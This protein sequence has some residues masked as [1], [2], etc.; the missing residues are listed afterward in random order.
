MTSVLSAKRWTNTSFAMHQGYSLWL[1]ALVRVDFLSGSDKFVSIHC[2]PIVTV[3]KTPIWRST[4]IFKQESG[5]MLRPSY[6]DNPFDCRFIKHEITLDL[7]GG[8]MINYD[9]SISGLGWIGIQGK[10]PTTIFLYL[11]E[12]VEFSIRDDPMMPYEIKEKGL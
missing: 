7:D 11:P 6:T 9:L 10:G 2:S 12:S 1:G 8:G 4:E 3:H 5:K